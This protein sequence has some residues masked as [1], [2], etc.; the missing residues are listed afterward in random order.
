MKNT[1]R[2]LKNRSVATSAPQA[3]TTPAETIT[4]IFYSSKKVKEAARVEFPLAE[5]TKILSVCKKLK[6]TPTA[7]FHLA[8]RSKLEGDK[9]MLDPDAPRLSAQIVQHPAMGGAQ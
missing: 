3:K 6:C 4:V 2:V 8:I 7:F 1:I 9:I 5:F